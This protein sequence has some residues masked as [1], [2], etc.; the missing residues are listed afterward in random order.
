MVFL[1]TRF[2]IK[3]FEEKK[4]RKTQSAIEISVFYCGRNGPIGLQP[5]VCGV[6]NSDDQSCV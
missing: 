4:C 6:D 1:L 3:F 5:E 2:L